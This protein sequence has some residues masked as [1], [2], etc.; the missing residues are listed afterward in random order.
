MRSQGFHQFQ[1]PGD[2]SKDKSTESFTVTVLS[3]SSETN[4]GITT[5]VKRRG[6][7]GGVLDVR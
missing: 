4:I 5:G 3:S 2:K 7:S 6:G 1:K